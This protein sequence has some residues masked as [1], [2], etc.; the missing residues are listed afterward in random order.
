MDRDRPKHDAVTSEHL[1]HVR[2]TLTDTIEP[3]RIP[4]PLGIEEWQPHVR[5][6]P[7]AGA[8]DEELLM[9]Y[10]LPK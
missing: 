6:H 5:R 4:G 9:L 2:A 1:K 7:H 3:V 8:S 10:P